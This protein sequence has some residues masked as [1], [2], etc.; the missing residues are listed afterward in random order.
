MKQIKDYHHQLANFL[1]FDEDAYY[2][3]CQGTLNEDVLEI[4]YNLEFINYFN[5]YVIKLFKKRI[6]DVDQ[7]NNITVLIHRFNLKIDSIEGINKTQTS[8]LWQN[9]IEQ[10]N[11]YCG[12][13][14]VKFYIEEMQKRNPD[15]LD[16][17]RIK[18]LRQN[19]IYIDI[20]TFHSLRKKVNES[21]SNDFTFLIAL[22]DESETSPI[23]VNGL[24]VDSDIETI[25][26]FFQSLNAM[27]EEEKDFITEEIKERIK[28]ILKYIKQNGTAKQLIK[29]KNIIA[30]NNE[31]I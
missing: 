30:V 11:N 9:M 27:M 10:F 6:L 29:A 19:G 14:N 31:K 12:F 16:L 21:M 22:L 8:N 15:D 28:I 7:M 13:N 25:E 24:F 17:K 3:V 4:I 26:A 2:D 23:G 5:K 20:S 1:I 18:K